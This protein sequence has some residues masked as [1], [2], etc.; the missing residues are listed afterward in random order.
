M[1]RWIGKQE[2]DVVC[3]WRRHRRCSYST[4]QTE[5]STIQ[6]YRRLMPVGISTYS[7][8]DI[9]RATE[10]IND[11]KLKIDVIHP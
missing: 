7:P 5:R 9:N 1:N 10:F 4:F 8:Y 3:A 2:G 11:R 6:Q